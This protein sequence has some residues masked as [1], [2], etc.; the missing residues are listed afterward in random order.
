MLWRRA[1]SHKVGWQAMR[2]EW[3]AGQ[4]VGS[5]AGAARVGAFGRAIVAR[6]QNFATRQRVGMKSLIDRFVGPRE[7]IDAAAF[8]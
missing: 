1:S 3:P 7:A 5:A 2:P 8:A 6:R 4:G